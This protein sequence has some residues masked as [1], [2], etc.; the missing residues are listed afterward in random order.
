MSLDELQHVHAQDVPVSHPVP[1]TKRSGWAALRPLLLRMHFYAGLLMAPLLFIAAATGLL[2]ALSWQAEK[3]VYADEL[4]IARV[5]ESALPL[6]AQV[7]AAQGAAPQGHV[8]GVWPAPEAEATT[9]V[10]MEG[11]GLGE[12]E[13]LTVFVDPYTAAVRGQLTTAGDALP[14][15]AWLSEFHSSLQLGEFGRVYSEL[16]ASWLWVVALGGLALWIGRRR[17]GRA[18]LLLPDRAATGRRRTLSWHGTVGLWAVAGLVALSATGLTWS[19]YAGENIGQLQD[20]LG[21]ATP[22]VSASLKG[23][24]GAGGADEHAGHVMTEDME[25]P[26]PAPTA[27][28]GIDKAVDAARAAGVTEHLQVTLPAKGK[29]YVVKEKDKQVPVHL[30]A[31]AVDPA[32]GRVMDELRFADYPF[33]AQLTRFGIDLHMGQTFGLAN[34]LA[35]AALAVALMFLVFW[36]YRMWWLRRPTKERL[37]RAGRPQP[38]GALRKVPVTL[39]LPL[40]A[41]TAVVGWFVPLL[42]ISL[43]A[44][45]AVDVLLGFVAARR[46]AKAAV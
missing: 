41:V 43:V 40:A 6:S 14:L 10:I 42:G 31:V 2:Y 23:A 13:T 21:G 24:S 9:R 19:K 39:L 30:D 27:D 5:G 33:L 25:M 17:A 12:G 3:I 18:R 32:D 20:R 44:F 1:D 11:P 16:A 35:L 45:L 46:A 34:Q 7:Q 22:S 26:P 36:G 28:I 4:T 37:L 8:V 15:R 29:G 38:R